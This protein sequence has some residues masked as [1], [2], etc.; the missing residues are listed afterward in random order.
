MM[1]NTSA[2]RWNQRLII[3]HTGPEHCAHASNSR[4][5]HL[6]AHNMLNRQWRM[7]ALI[8]ITSDHPDQLL[9][10]FTSFSGHILFPSAAVVGGDAIVVVLWISLVVICAFG[11]LERSGMGRRRHRKRRRM[12]LKR[13]KG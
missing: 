12:E 2:D 1:A 4:G 8:M 10:S 9:P 3:T 5:I 6:V 13:R 7:D 11:L